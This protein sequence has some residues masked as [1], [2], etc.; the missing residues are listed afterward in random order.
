[1]VPSVKPVKEMPGYAPIA[2]NQ[3]R[4][5]QSQPTESGLVTG[6]ETWMASDLLPHL[7]GCEFLPRGQVWTES[8]ETVQFGLRHVPIWQRLVS[9]ILVSVGKQMILE[10]EA[11]VTR[12]EVIG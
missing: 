6:L 1:M 5:L 10:L 12:L 3:S 9:E 8:Q 7:N 4:E 2:L 11:V